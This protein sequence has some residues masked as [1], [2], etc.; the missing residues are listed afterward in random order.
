MKVPEF[1]QFIRNL[2]RADI[3][4]EEVDAWILQGYDSQ[5]LLLKVDEE[6]HLPEHTHGDQWGIVIDGEMELTIEGKAETYHRGDSYFI[7]A[8]A[9][10]KAILHE[11]FRALDIFADKNRYRIETRER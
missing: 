4:L 6:K 11:G 7:P 1:P 9:I 3:P 2:P 8:G 5:V 10:H